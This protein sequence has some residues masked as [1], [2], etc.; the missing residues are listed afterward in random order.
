M[1]R[2]VRRLITDT[3]ETPKAPVEKLALATTHAN[4]EGMRAAA[5]HPSRTHVDGNKM[6]V[7]RGFAAR[8]EEG[9]RRAYEA[10][11]KTFVDGETE[12]V[13]GTDPTDYRDLFADALIPLNLTRFGHR[14]SQAEKTLKANPQVTT[15]VGHSKPRY[16]RFR[17][18]T[19]AIG[20]SK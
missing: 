1:Y 2:N 18:S 7:A 12:Y 5:A 13:A 6:Y 11:D 3:S 19:M 9:L 14:Y 15:L 4:R 16:R 17:S 20:T 10:P 8:N